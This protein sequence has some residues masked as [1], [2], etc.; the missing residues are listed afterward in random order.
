MRKIRILFVMFLTL[1]ILGGCDN[2][3]KGVTSGKGLYH[4]DKN[5]DV[6]EKVVSV[7]EKD[8]FVVMEINQE[9]GSVLLQKGEDKI[10]QFSYLFDEKSLLYDKY[11]KLIQFDK[12][13]VGDVVNLETDNTKQKIKTLT[14]SKQVWKIDD[15]SDLIVES[16]GEIASFRGKKYAWDD[17]VGIFFQKKQLTLEELSRMDLLQITGK[18]KKILSIKVT[19]GHGF[20][21]FT[22]GEKFEGGY[23]LLGNLLA[24]QIQKDLM[25]PI[26]AGKILLSVMKDGMGGSKEVEILENQKLEV[27]LG[28]FSQEV[29]GSGEVTF[30]LMQEG[31][32]LYINGTIVDLTQPQRLNYG[33]YQIKVKA[34]GYDSWTRTLVVRSEK[35]TLVID[36]DEEKNTETTEKKSTT[37]SSTDKTHTPTTPTTPTAPTTTPSTT[38]TKTPTT[39][40]TTDTSKK[41][42]FSTKLIDDLLNMLLGVKEKKT[43]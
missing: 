8:I 41:D 40:V 14:L 34:E 15:V 3:G 1:L 6:V 12:L 13:E 16:N 22:N 36:L 18:D 21:L 31:A 30:T 2:Q 42:T 19:T 7:K 37:D 29:V 5:E 39:D 38:T 24:V 32:K 17:Q 11:K 9:E 27:D 4:P 43:P 35:T 28:A 20:V 26:R 23:I 25:L 10:Q 33:V